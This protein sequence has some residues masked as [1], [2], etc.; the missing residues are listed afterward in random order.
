MTLAKGKVFV[1]KE[2]LKQLL[3]LPEGVEIVF[4]KSATNGNED[5][6]D[7]LIIS[8]NETPLTEKNVAIGLMRRNTIQVQQI[9]IPI[10]QPQV[11]VHKGMAEIKISGNGFE[12]NSFNGQEEKTPQQLF[13]DIVGKL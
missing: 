9:Q 7:F 8:A 5:G 2:Q 13:E 11:Q 6:F 1:S 12:I 3:A 10:E 4:A